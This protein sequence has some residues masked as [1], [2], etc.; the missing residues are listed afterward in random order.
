MA[1]QWVSTGKRFCDICKV[2]FGNNRASQDHHDRGER[3]KAMLQQRIRETMQKG[4]KQE[5]ADMKLNGTLAKMEA[6]AAASM[7]RNGEA[8]VA[9]PSLPATGLRMNIFDPSKHKDVGS[10]AK[11]MSSRREAAGNVK[12]GAQSAAV[13][14]PN[15]KI[16]KDDVVSAYRD[17][18]NPNAAGPALPEHLAV[19]YMP[20]TQVQCVEIQ[21]VRAKNPSAP[22]GHY[23]WNLF[24]NSTRWT[25]PAH[26]YTEQQYEQKCA[27]FEEQR[28]K[29]YYGMDEVQA[30]RSGKT[31]VESYIKAQISKSG[32]SEQVEANR[33]EQNYVDKPN[34]KFKKLTKEEKKAQWEERRRQKDTERAEDEERRREAEEDEDVSDEESDEDEEE[35]EIIGTPEREALVLREHSS[36][37]PPEELQEQLEEPPKI[38]EIGLIE[39]PKPS[40]PTTPGA[41]FGAWQRVEKSEKTTEIFESPLTAR[42][43]E[44]EE[45]RKEEEEKKRQEE[46]KFEFGEKTAS[47]MT[48]KV[49]GPIEFK[50]KTANRNIRKREE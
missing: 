25:A 1:E 3:H 43:R 31:D 5:L 30:V 14:A 46:P 36:T 50:K 4:K 37:P 40:I 12:R 9:G 11:E 28:T 47:V 33:K 48:K 6:A 39:P 18:T 41:P 10:M 27:E 29:N 19:G 2:W 45:E 34:N 17:L 44:E 26:F 8:I 16:T 35:F 32:L 49:K 13:G 15:V 23:Y 7:A 24:D 20:E 21:W 42:F 22:P 38:P